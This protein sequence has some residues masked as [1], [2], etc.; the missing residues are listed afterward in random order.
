M[1]ALEGQVHPTPDDYNTLRSMAHGHSP[2]PIE[3]S[4]LTASE[5]F[6]LDEKRK[7][8]IAEM[9]AHFRAGGTVGGVSDGYHTFDELYHHRALLFATIC[10]MHPEL[11]WKSKQHDDPEFP[12]FDGMF[13]CGIKTPQ[14]QATYH[15]DLDPYW[16][17]FHVQELERA[18]KYDGHT[19]DD[20]INR[21]FS[22]TEEMN[23]E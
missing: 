19:P 17:M 23:D 3:K 13:I 14:G 12:M 5:I 11:A 10:N 15:Y 6:H 8:F 2:K 1:D 22:L 21:I 4:Y 20:A 18:P 7:A 9:T 16:D